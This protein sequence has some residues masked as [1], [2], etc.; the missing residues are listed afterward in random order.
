MGWGD[1]RR[2]LDAAAYASAAQL[3][4]AFLAWW[5]GSFGEDDYG[6]GYG[7][8]FGLACLCLF[9]PLVLPVLGLI[10]AVVHLV[11]GWW[12]ALPLARRFPG[13]PRW[14]WQ[15]AG[16]TVVAALFAGPAALLLDWPF[17]TTTSVLAAFGVWP[18]LW[19]GFVRRRAERTGRSWGCLGLGLASALTCVGLCALTLLGG[20]LAVATG[21]VREYEPPRLSAARLT[22]VWR[23]E[24]GAVLR[25]LPGGRAEATDVPVTAPDGWDFV[26]CRGTR[27]GTWTAGIRAGRDGASVTLGGGCGEELFWSA[28]GT[29]E[30][31]QLFATA[32]DPD[33]PALRILERD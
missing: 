30:E 5:I 6:V 20:L 23:G 3:P 4:V 19:C 29:A 2:D 13:R 31:P 1:I 32:G 16:T 10:H 14:V 22:G 7:G 8:A 9:L 33:S 21:L 18:L 24:D 25:L 11:P 12:L 27:T 26:T 17:V 28:G 15:L